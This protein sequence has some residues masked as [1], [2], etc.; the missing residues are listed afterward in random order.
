MIAADVAFTT[1]EPMRALVLLS[2]TFVDE[3]AWTQG[4]ARRKG[5]P[6]FIAHGTS[7]TILKYD[8]ATRLAERMRAAGLVV[9]WVPFAGGHEIPAEVVVALNQFLAQVDAGAGTR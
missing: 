9:T 7:D 2:G 4:M 5:L 3:R 1:D 6:V 8:V